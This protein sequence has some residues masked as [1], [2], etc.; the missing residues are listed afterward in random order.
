MNLVV[1][2]LRDV[3]GV[4]ENINIEMEDKN[5]YRQDEVRRLCDSEYAFL[6]EFIE[7]ILHINMNLIHN[8]CDQ[9]LL[10][11]CHSS[12]FLNGHYF[13]ECHSHSF[14]YCHSS[15]NHSFLEYHS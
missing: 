9:N 15:F 2:K 1:S 7:F 4:G 6:T 3:E 14:L 10:L 11:A 5:R 8:F 13:L 12:T